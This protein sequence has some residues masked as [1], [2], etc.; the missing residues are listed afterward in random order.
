[1]APRHVDLDDLLAGIGGC[2]CLG[3]HDEQKRLGLVK[4]ILET[5][6]VEIKRAIEPEEKAAA[7]ERQAKAGPQSGRGAK[8]TGGGNLPQAVKGKTRDKVAKATGKKAKTLAKA[9]AVVAQYGFVEGRDYVKVV[10]PNRDGPARIEY[11]ATLSMGK[12]LA[13]VE[14]NDRGRALRR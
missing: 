3:F 2:V 8:P 7:K 9:E 10:C 5:K 6:A 1:M 13:M 14:N 12:E 11:H 4:P